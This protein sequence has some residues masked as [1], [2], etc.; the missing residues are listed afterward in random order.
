MSLTE[1]EFA[2]VDKLDFDANI[3]ARLKMFVSAPLREFKPEDTVQPG[4][5]Y[6][7][8]THGRFSAKAKKQQIEILQNILQRSPSA[9]ELISGWLNKLE[10]PPD[11]AEQQHLEAES[12]NKEFWLAAASYANYIEAESERIQKE[13]RGGRVSIPSFWQEKGL[14]VEERLE[15]MKAYFAGKPEPKPKKSGGSDT[16]IV[17]TVE[18]F[19]WKVNSSEWRKSFSA[20]GYRLVELL[21]YHFNQD[22]DT[23]EEAL[24]FVASR[25]DLPGMGINSLP[26][27][28]YAIGSEDNST[29]LFQGNETIVKMGVDKY[30]VCR[31]ALHRVSGGLVVGFLG[32]SKPSKA[33]KA[34]KFQ[35][36]IESGTAAPNSGL[37]TDAILAQLKNWDEGYGLEIEDADHDSVS[38]VFKKLPPDIRLLCSE[39]L[40]FCP[41]L[42][43]L[44]ADGYDANASRV[45]E[46]AYLLRRT[47][48]V[49]FWWD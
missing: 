35:L 21:Q 40:L 49:K 4:K 45:R 18:R 47:G 22:F 11:Q 12:R 13:A 33:K 43:V 37:G 10:G 36:L 39:M 17:F 44:H 42:D 7:Q 1:D 32:K 48:R 14:S 19:T 31:N 41:D 16:G 28:S 30:D 9:A 3:V 25:P 26:A 8:D 29:R 2:L 27:H 15:Q 6:R 38:V 34:D 20:D 5:D 23:R 24:D 46:F